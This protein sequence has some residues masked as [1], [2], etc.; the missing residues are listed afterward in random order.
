VE[1]WF[2]DVVDRARRQSS[3][4][5]IE[6]RRE[7]IKAWLGTVTVSTIHQR[8]LD[9]L[10]LSVSESSLRRF[11]SANFALEATRASVVVLRDT[12]PPGGEAHSP[13]D[14]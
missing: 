6:G 13:P 2:P 11:V 5:E 8:L 9:D 4:P 7:R 14:R 12:P 3:W 1:G 10:G